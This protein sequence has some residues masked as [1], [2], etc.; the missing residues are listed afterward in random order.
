MHY[1]EACFWGQVPS[2]CV[3]IWWEW[4]LGFPP[5][6]SLSSST[7]FFPC[8]IRGMPTDVRG[9]SPTP[10]GRRE[11]RR[12]NAPGVSAQSKSWKIKVLGPLAW[13]LWTVLVP[14]RSRILLPASPM[15]KSTPCQFI[16]EDFNSLSSTS[17]LLTPALYPIILILAPVL[18]H[19]TQC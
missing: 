11:D 9:N 15:L 14:L 7:S 18:L 10:Y 6:V 16:K 2:D 4:T 13:I 12:S 1:K 5:S 19:L 8:G 17:V 3:K